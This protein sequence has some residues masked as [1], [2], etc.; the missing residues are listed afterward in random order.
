MTYFIN[1]NILDKVLTFFWTVNSG[2]NAL[3]LSISLS[4]VKEIKRD[5][6]SNGE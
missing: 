2:I 5:S 3:N 6:L 1:N 4:A